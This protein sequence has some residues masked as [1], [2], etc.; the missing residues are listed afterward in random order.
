MSRTVNLT[1][2]RG[3]LIH[4]ATRAMAVGAHERREGTYCNVGVRWMPHAAT[5]RFDPLD[6]FD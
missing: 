2:R 6:W 5:F 4:W 3:T 1:L